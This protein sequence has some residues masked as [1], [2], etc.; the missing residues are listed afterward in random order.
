MTTAQW[1]LVED[2]FHAALERPDDVGAAWLAEQDSDPAI[3]DE[4]RSLL[5]A[6]RDQDR[7]GVGQL[8]APTPAAESES[9]APLP[10]DRFGPYRLIRPL[11]RGGMG[12]VYLAERADGAFQMQ[13]AVK[14]I[15]LPL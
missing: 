11:G 2:L 9:S 4:V 12:S 7:P 14:V 6:L 15:G 3:R 5:D 10:A 1:R 8:S 13:A